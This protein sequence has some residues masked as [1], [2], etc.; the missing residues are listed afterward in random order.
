MKKTKF[1]EKSDLKFFLIVLSICAIARTFL[2]K[3]VVVEG[4]SMHPTLESGET[5]FSFPLG[6]LS[7]KRGDIVIINVSNYHEGK[8]YY[9]VKRVI[10][11]PGETVKVVG[12][13]VYINGTP[14]L[15]TYPVY[16]HDAEEMTVTLNDDEYYCMGDNRSHSMDSRY[17]G[18]FKSSDIVA[19]GF[20]SFPLIFSR[21]NAA[22]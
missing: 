3:P 19:K 15:E 7:L 20:L 1:V 22:N 17:Y 13:D 2:L 4:Q 10:G 12:T 18:P 16:E 5:G 8:Q 6:K 11:L 9:I 14:L 21:K